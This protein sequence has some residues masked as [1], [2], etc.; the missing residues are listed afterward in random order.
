MRGPLVQSLNVRQMSARFSGRPREH[1]ERQLWVG[2]HHAPE[3]DEIG[4]AVAHRGLA[5][6]RQPLLQIAVAGAD[7]G[8]RRELL[9]EHADRGN[10]ARDADERILRRQVAVGRR[11]E[12]RPLNVRVVVRAARGDAHPVD[13][14][15][16][17]RAQEGARRVE[18][19]R[20][21]RI[22]HQAEGAP[23]VARVRFGH[24][25][26]VRR[27]VDRAR[28]RTPRAA[29]QSAD[30]ARAAESPPPTDRRNVVRP[31]RPPPYFP[32]RLS[33]AEQLVTEIAV[34]VLDVD[35]IEA[36]SRGDAGRVDEALDE[37]VELVV[38]EQMRRHAG[39]KAPVEHRMHVRGHRRPAAAGIRPRVTSRVGELQAD[40]QIGGRSRRRLVRAHED[41]PQIDQVGFGMRT[42]ARADWDWRVRRA[43]PRTLRRP[44]SISRRSRRSAASAGASGRSGGRPASRPSPPSAGC[45]SDCPP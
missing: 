2:E 16:D 4:E 7:D 18:R 34:A 37:R 17:Q 40:E 14:G 12:R 39:G 21:R 44:R 22:G 36:G 27:L 38:R 24:A 19:R 42:V 31:S 45:R 29:R 5:D 6:V 3:A 9:L 25:D 11:K 33:R 32:G 30:P 26:A 20:R 1:V 10:L 41:L 28:R 15:V 35:E 8:E 13:P 43:A 23:I